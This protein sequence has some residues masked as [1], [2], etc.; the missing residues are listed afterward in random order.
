MAGVSP[1]VKAHGH[2]TLGH[3]VLTLG[4]LTAL[5]LAALVFAVAIGSADV[6]LKE[7]LAALVGGGD[8]LSR[9]L[10]LELRLPRALA[11]FAPRKP[12]SARSG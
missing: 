2:L 1:S 4:V 8:A 11:A 5:A 12:G 6:S 10:I 3:L 7:S 9:T